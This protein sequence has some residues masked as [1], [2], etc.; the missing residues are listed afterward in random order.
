LLFRLSRMLSRSQRR[1][2]LPP[3]LRTSDRCRA[4]S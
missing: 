3:K 2:R 1:E 4:G